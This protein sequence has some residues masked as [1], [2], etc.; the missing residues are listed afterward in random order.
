[1]VSRR[2]MADHAA[3]GLAALGL[4][5]Q[6]AAWAVDTAAFEAKAAKYKE[7]REKQALNAPQSKPLPGKAELQ[8]QRD[9]TKTKLIRECG[10]GMK[11]GKDCGQGFTSYPADAKYPNVG[12]LT[13][14]L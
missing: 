12:G 10:A 4:L 5:G 6:P 2:R 14:K 3:V 8:K 7:E 13:T 11:A 1:M 9:Y